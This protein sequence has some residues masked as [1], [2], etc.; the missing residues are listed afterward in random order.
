MNKRRHPKHGTSKRSH[1]N[2]RNG[3]KV[4]LEIGLRRLMEARAAVSDRLAKL[5]AKIKRQEARIL[6]AAD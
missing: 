1:R 5:D 2:Q 4:W 6:E 3:S